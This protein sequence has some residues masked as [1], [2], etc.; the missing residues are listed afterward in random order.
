MAP[1]F[2]LAILDDFQ[3]A[4]L[5][6][7][8]WERLTG[9]VEITVFRDHLADPDALAERLQ[10]FDMVFAIRERSP[11]PRS[12]LEKLP[13]LK[14]LITA[15]GRNRAIDAAYCAEK[16]IVFSGTPS[17]GAPTVDL[18]WGLIIGLMRDIPAQQDS[19]RARGWQTV[20]GR[21]LEGRR[22][23]VIGL[24]NLGGKVAKVG[25]AF[26]M[27]VVA[28]S[29]NL[30]A[31]RAAEVGVAR[32]E[33]D[34]LLSTSD[35][36]TLHVVLSDRSRG[37]IGADQIAL[38]KSD[39][40]LIN[41]SRGPLVDQEALIDA[42]KL[43]R[44]GGAGLDVYDQEPLPDDHPLLDAPHTLLTPH[45]GYVTEENY[46]AYFEG[47]VEAVEAFLAGSPIRLIKPA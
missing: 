3:G 20:I 22:L 23:G 31:E 36:V 32:V 14:L 35:V 17:F 29:P 37:M 28:W 33:R 18:T 46:R 7:G 1:P 40:L 4:S 41:T 24:G 13:N 21:G 30:T 26:G 8:P 19:L 39:A 5:A 43:G 11:M 47:A 25:Q 6:A 12:L 38:M 27:E 44:I 45:L 10:A 42:L 2:K 15:G 16:G 9:K 34:E